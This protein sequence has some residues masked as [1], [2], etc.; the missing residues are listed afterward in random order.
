MALRDIDFSEDIEKYEAK[1]FTEE[2]KFSHCQHTRTVLNEHRTELRCP[3]CNKAW[4]GSRLGELK[5]LL[6]KQAKVI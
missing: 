3:D 2:V 1:H 4:G 6:D 5:H